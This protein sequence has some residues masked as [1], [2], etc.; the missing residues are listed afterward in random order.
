MLA[1]PFAGPQVELDAAGSCSAES[2]LW[3][4]SWRIVIVG[5]NGSVAQLTAWK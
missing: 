2:I 5:L 3:P 1:S 4:P